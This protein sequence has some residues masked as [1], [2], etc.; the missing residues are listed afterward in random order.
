MALKATG[1]MQIVKTLFNFYLDA[2]IHVALA[3]TSLVGATVLL[4]HLPWKV[5]L[6]AF[7]FFST[8]VCYNFVKYGVDAYM[9]FVVPNKNHKPIQWFSFGCFGFALYFLSCLSWDIWIAVGVLSF[10]VALYALP[11]LPHAQNLRSWGGLKI[12]SVALVWTGVTVGLPLMVAHRSM[13][14]DMWVL[15]VQRFILIM[16]LLLPFEIR[17]LRWDDKRLKTL[18]QVLGIR[19]TQRLGFVLAV[20]FFVLTLLKREL[21]FLEIEMHAVLSMLLIGGCLSKNKMQSPYFAS[22]WVEGIPIGW[23]GLLG[24]AKHCC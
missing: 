19:N 9:Y 17:D 14:W 4:A 13:T 21:F 24:L 12:Y 7:V 6:L 22:F 5:S 16:V 8:I 10:F 11:V 20:V 23:V 3:A 1:V 2:S 18:P 15:V